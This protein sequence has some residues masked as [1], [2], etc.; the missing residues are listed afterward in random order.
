MLFVA[1]IVLAAGGSRRMGSP[2]Q[3]LRLDGESLVR[4]AA[5]AAL[6]SHCARVLVVVGSHAELIAREV[7][8]LPLECVTNTDWQRGIG[9]SIRAAVEHIAGAAPPFDAVLITAVD[10]PAVTAALLDR[11]IAAGET[12]PAGLAACEYD[13]TV[14]VPALFA[15]R[16]FDALRILD[17]DRGGKAILTAHADG[18]ARIP[19]APAAL[20][21]DTPADYERVSK[22]PTDS[23]PSSLPGEGG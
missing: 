4:R 7:E 18:V 2:K 8:D 19:F 1:G 23:S 6:A 15:R 14:G 9:T 13:G 12:A 17:G 3:I 16:H 22:R 5:K 10:Q 11:L 21:I 20:D